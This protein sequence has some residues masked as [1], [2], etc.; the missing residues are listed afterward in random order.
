MATRTRFANRA[1]STAPLPTGPIFKARSAATPTTSTSAVIPTARPYK[2]FLTPQLHRRFTSAALLLLGLCYVAAIF[3]SPSA[4]WFWTVFPLSL[5]GIRTLLL[6]IPCLTVFIVRISGMHPGSL[7]TTSPVETVFFRVSSR[8]T[9]EALAWYVT[10][11]M[12]YG[13]V[14]IWC[15]TSGASGNLAWVDVGRQGY[16]RSRA[17]ENAV[18]L[19]CV[20]L[21][22]AVGMTALHFRRDTD[23][24]QFREP[25]TPS[26]TVGA[27][28]NATAATTRAADITPVNQLRSL[29][30]SVLQDTV[31]LALPGTVLTIPVYYGILRQPAWRMIYPIIRFLSKDLPSYAVPTGITNVQAL[32]WQAFT[33]AILLVLLWEASNAAFTVYVSGKPVKL[34]GEVFTSEMKAPTGRITSKS[35]DPNGSLLRGLQAR[36]DVPRSFAFWELDL[37][38]TPNP[39][40]PILDARRKSI[41]SDLDRQPAT[42]WQQISALC[43]AE[44]TAITSRVAVAQKPLPQIAK[45]SSL[46]QQQQD[47][48]V[49]QRQKSLAL[50]RISDRAVSSDV[51]VAL[52]NQQTT[53]GSLAR[54]V[55]QSPGAANPVVPRAKRAL[56]YGIQRSGGA[57]IWSRI[58]V[59]AQAEGYVMQFLQSPAGEPFRQTFA[60]RMQAVVF[61]VPYG[62]ASTIVHAAR[63]LTRLAVA[64]LRDD[65]YGQVAKSVPAIVRTFTATI[66]SITA[67]NA[68]L[69]PSWTDVHFQPN[70][71]RRV[72]EVDAVVE[73][74]KEG[75]QEVLLAFQEYAQGLGLTRVEVREAGEVSGR[76]REMAR[77]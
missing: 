35:R 12:L 7:T 37:I 75:L 19:R 8:A 59:K 13:E 29:L 21:V 57:D 51:D 36:K 16:E 18:L 45:P 1:T 27:A 74:L 72:K 31:R 67:F 6:F 76:G 68:A 48:L 52:A 30:P 20:Y 47:Q 49:Q 40:N 46:K 34:T 42:T 32:A 10:G 65:D 15:C 39:L 25:A 17:N 26:R 23:A 56:E 55:G 44:L 61:G 41:F 38:T 24:V 22:L 43:L 64:S 77:V 3:L 33:S 63:A 60:R 62:N 66:K 28:H 70:R 2:D 58:T 50:P 4:S 54:S 5:T 14:Y 71:D 73:V 9:W 11:A 53:F 69:A